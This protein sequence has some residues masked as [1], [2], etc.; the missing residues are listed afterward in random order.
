M[1]VFQYTDT[2]TFIGRYLL[3][4][5]DV[6]VIQIF[7]SYRLFVRMIGRFLSEGKLHTGFAQLLYRLFT[8]ASSPLTPET[9]AYVQFVEIVLP[10]GF[11]E[12]V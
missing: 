6:D 7:H 12:R 1:V 2:H 9:D 5:R 8:Q 4:F 11:R 10:S 3:K